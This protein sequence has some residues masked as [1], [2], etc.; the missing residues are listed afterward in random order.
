MD[1][2]L[3]HFVYDRPHIKYFLM[4]HQSLGAHADIIQ[5]EAGNTKTYRW[6]H[7]GVRPLGIGINQQCGQCNRLRTKKP[8]ESQDHSEIVSTCT[9]CKSQVTYTM[10]DGWKWVDR[11]PAKADDRGAWIVKEE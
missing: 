6:T 3:M 1:W 8:K 5:F 2:T 4:E 11:C 10:L 7:V 9:E